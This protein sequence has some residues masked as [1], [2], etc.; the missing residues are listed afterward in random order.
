VPCLSDP[1]G[2]HVS[3]G[4]ELNATDDRRHFGATG[5][6]VLEGKHLQPFRVAPEA[7]TQRIEAEIAARLLGDHGS[8]TR[9]RLCYREV[10]SATNQLT[11][12][13]AIV[14]AGMVTTH[15]V[16]CLKA[17]LDADAQ[18]F[19]CGVLNSFVAN[20]LVRLRVG[21]H[22]T[23][24]IM[25]QLRVPRPPAA[26]AIVVRIAAA[27]RLL[28]QADDEIVLARL[29]ADVARLYGLDRDR[30]SHIV[31]TFPLVDRARRDAALAA[32]QEREGN[33]L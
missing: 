10:A 30:F 27:A 26:A 28:A 2:W 17:P 21:T 22:V 20:Y 32:F 33:G 11:L 13:A 25:A 29:Q 4:R 16:F 31:S 3:F 18:S 6:P 15:T 23:A 12:I 9:A 1:A 8:F 24:A 14:P 5:L 19:L 7:A